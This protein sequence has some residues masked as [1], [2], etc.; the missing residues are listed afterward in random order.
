MVQTVVN[1]DELLTDAELLE[2]QVITNNAPADGN[3]KNR[4]ME[5]LNIIY[6]QACL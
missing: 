5:N 3:V 6:N 1:G 4:V 2:L